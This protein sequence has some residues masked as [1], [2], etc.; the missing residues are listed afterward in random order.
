M[1]IDKSEI[2]ILIVDDTPQN[3]DILGEYLSEYKIKAAADGEKALRYIESGNKPHLILLD[4]MM[5][6]MDGYEVC[7]RLKRNDKTKDIPVVFIT[8][9]S[10][11]EDKVKGFQLGAVDYITKPF[12]LEEVKSRIEAHIA[13]SLYR[14][15]LENIN[16]K[17]EIKVQERTRDLVTAKEKAEEANKLKSHFLS[18]I[19]HEL[20]TPMAGILG[21][22]EVLVEES[23]SPELKEFAGML[24]SSARRLKDTIESILTLSKLDT[25]T[26]LI[27]PEECNIAS[28]VNKQIEKYMPVV[29]EKG[30][31]LTVQGS[32]KHHEA[33]VDKSA[34]SLIFENLL[35]NAIKY[36]EKG[37]VRI[38][39]FDEMLDGE[40]AIC[41]SIADTGIGIPLDKQQIIFEEFRQV[42]EGMERNFEGVGL[43]LSLVKKYVDAAGGKIDLVSAPGKGT[44]LTVK[45]KQSRREDASEKTLAAIEPK[46]PA[47]KEIK[48]KPAILLVEDDFV[49]I[50]I[51]KFYLRGFADI[52]VAKDGF[53]AIELAQKKQ[54]DAVLMDINLGRGLSGVEVTKEL[55][56]MEKYKT[57]PIIACTAFAMVGDEQRFLQE[58]C[59][60]YLSK[61][62]TKEDLIELLKKAMNL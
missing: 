50:E 7:K 25:S 58:G 4:I 18:L 60:H 24:F 26:G 38:V 45:L 3:I 9:M 2:T 5:P 44:T 59:T 32:W 20:R 34:F 19:S 10:E 17:L 37:E 29:N 57:I 61:P 53:N 28:E 33:Y 47:Q 36:T 14:S 8:A 31:K 6:G 46:L 52:D 35:N 51:A 40:D 16:Q 56:T 55:L 42:Y 62:Y 48:G 15:E 11:V 22:S 41:F 27:R 49:N 1:A 13:L 30:I 21:F 43:G 12:Q 39:L 23:T 54:Y